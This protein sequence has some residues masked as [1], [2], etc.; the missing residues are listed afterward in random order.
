MNYN[1]IYW[2]TKTTNIYFLYFWRMP[3]DSLPDEGLQIAIFLLGSQT[4][5][6]SVLF[7]LSYKDI[8]PIIG[9]FFYA[10]IY[11]LLLPK[12]PIFKYHHNWN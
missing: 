12:G 5:T 9:L 2:M 10:L 7:S 3:V 4:N 1:T 8:N 6:H 11:T